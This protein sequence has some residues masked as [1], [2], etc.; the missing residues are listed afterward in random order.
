V[1][2]KRS[3]HFTCHTQECQKALKLHARPSACRPHPPSRE[4]QRGRGPGVTSGTLC[5]PTR[6]RP[7]APSHF[8]WDNDC[9]RGSRPA[10]RHGRLAWTIRSSGH[11][12]SILSQRRWWQAS[13]ALL[14]LSGPRARCAA[15]CLALTSQ[16]DHLVH[17]VRS[18]PCCRSEAISE[19]TPATRSRI[20]G[21]FNVCLHLD[22]LRAIGNKRRDNYDE[23]FCCRFVRDFLH[24]LAWHLPPAVIAV[25][26]SPCPAPITLKW[27][28]IIPG[29]LAEPNGGARIHATLSAF[30][31]VIR[32]ASDLE[33]LAVMFAAAGPRTSWRQIFIPGLFGRYRSLGIRMVSHRRGL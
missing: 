21:R 33:D 8:R 18:Y 27:R 6:I 17:P 7:T 22:W 16:T 9:R 13:S 19:I 30:G 32:F 20:Y 26:R 12:C 31:G 29:R 3:S 5:R 28:H 4:S 1:P 15:W 24:T 10:H 23:N 11:A 14:P 2:K 25:A